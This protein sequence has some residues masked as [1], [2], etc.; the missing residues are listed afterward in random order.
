MTSVRDALQ[1]LA[2]AISWKEFGEC[3]AFVTAGPIM[4]IHEALANARAALSKQE[5]ATPAIQELRNIAEAKR[6]DRKHFDDDTSFADWAQ[7]RA[8]YTLSK[9]ANE[10]TVNSAPV[11]REVQ[12]D[13]PHQGHPDPTRSVPMQAAEARAAL[14]AAQPVPPEPL[15]HETERCGSEP[16]TAA[17]PSPSVDSVVDAL[18]RRDQPYYAQLDAI[19][20]VIGYG[21]AKQILQELWDAMLDRRYP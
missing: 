18:Q 2:A 10:S 12:S 17:T 5:A 13:D 9:D 19:G 16:A 1:E 6:F 15:G 21:R 20:S 3:R 4:T 7:S 8:R 14:K 11:L